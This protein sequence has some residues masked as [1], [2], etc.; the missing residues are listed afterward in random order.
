MHPKQQPNASSFNSK[1]LLRQLLTHF[2]LSFHITQLSNN[3]SRFH[4][5]YPPHS[6]DRLPTI[7][8]RNSTAHRLD[9]KFETSTGACTPMMAF[10]KLFPG[11]QVDGSAT[12][13]SGCF[14]Q[15]AFC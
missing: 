5:V 1:H 3:H 14:E 4:L 2:R 6:K 15:N 7:Q 9:K 12:P 10:Y 8:R 11:D 13:A